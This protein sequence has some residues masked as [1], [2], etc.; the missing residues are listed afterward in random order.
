MLSYNK[1]KRPMVPA[2][3]FMVAGIV[4]G[5]VTIP[6][7]VNVIAGFGRNGLYFRI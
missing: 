2:L 7:A 3:V 5:N 1:I 4:A 6:A